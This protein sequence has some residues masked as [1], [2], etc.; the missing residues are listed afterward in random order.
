MSCLRAKSVLINPE[1]YRNI[2]IP[3]TD[4]DRAITRKRLFEASPETHTYA[5]ENEDGKD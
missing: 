3:S 4:I 1:K 5:E 2:V